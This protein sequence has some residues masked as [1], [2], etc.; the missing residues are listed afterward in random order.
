MSES[1]QLWIWI[2][3]AVFTLGWEDAPVQQHR[4]VCGSD[5][6]RV[7]GSRERCLDPPDWVSC[8]IPGVDIPV[9]A[10]LE[11]SCHTVLPFGYWGFSSLSVDEW[12][13]QGLWGES[14]LLLSFTAWLELSFC[15][16]LAEVL[17]L[18]PG[19]IVL[20]FWDVHRGEQTWLRQEGHLS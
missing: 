10:S 16:H 20:Q 19:E 4:E 2:N 13:P 15:W 11:Q 18:L 8:C 7:P 5:W 3:V 9:P 17:L 14:V 1:Q 12:S 6:M